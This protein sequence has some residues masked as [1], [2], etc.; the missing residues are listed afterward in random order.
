MSILEFIHLITRNKKWTIF[1]PL[2]VGL[3]VTL[4]I[5]STPH[6]YTSHMVIYTGFASGLNSDNEFDAKIDF[7]ATSSGFDNLINIV[8]SKDLCKEV[9]VKLLAYMLHNPERMDALLKNSNNNLL[10]QTLTVGFVGHYRQANQEATESNLFQHL[11]NDSKNS[12]L[13]QLIYGEKKNCF[14]IQ[15]LQTMTAERLGFSDML[16]ISYECEDPFTCQKTLELT[17]I[18]LLE[19]YKAIRIGEA[20]SAV[21]YFRQQ[22]KESKTRL[23]IAE[24]NLKKFKSD[25]KIINYY[26]QS[27]YFA[28]QNERIGLSISDLHQELDGYT[29]ALQQTEEK[30][31]K[32]WMVQL[33]SEKVVKL[34]DSLTAQ[35]TKNAM[36]QVKNGT[37]IS[38]SDSGVNALKGSL[39]GSVDK[40]YALNNTIEGVPGKKLVEQWL[41]LV[42]GKEETES[43]L[44][45]LMGDKARFDKVFVSLS[46]IG[47][48]LTKY[49]KEVET[50]EKEYLNLLHNLN[51]AI[52]RERNLEV[53]QTI[54]VIDDADM[55]TI[56][57]PSKQII[58]I[59][60]SILAAFILA[61]VIL[62]IRRYL[63]D[64][65][66]S[67]IRMERL[68][69]IKTATAFISRSLRNIRPKAMNKLD[70]R[71]F[72]RWQIAMTKLIETN[73]AS[74]MIVLSINCPEEQIHFYLDKMIEY[75]KTK[76]IEA[77]YT[78]AKDYVVRLN[79]IDDYG[80][81]IPYE[82]AKDYAEGH[83]AICF[84]MA[85]RPYPELHPKL[86]LDQSKI[87]FIFFDASQKLNEYQIQ[88]VEDWKKT[89]ITVKGILVN[90]AEQYIAEYLG[91]IPRKRSKLRK[92]VKK[93]IKRY[94]S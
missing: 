25:N 64:S 49:E 22:V 9:S 84:V 75:L 16:K 24:D 80:A 15:T 37:E 73:E 7:H 87:I 50:A 2:L 8:G 72:E 93:E 54:D 56:P 46:P 51:Q 20:S 69:G 48:E 55:P 83:N 57:N 33:Q 59:I 58:I 42:V 13:S 62:I 68:L 60:A 91:E 86:V 45:A 23:E 82:P 47:S 92:F 90:T 17:K 74:A 70:K 35:I 53:S 44:K 28:D 34:R 5:W 81:L 32:R 76:S 88:L 71:S 94:A 36:N 38:Y 41:T 65:L 85:E 39:A 29:N 61:V 77:A 66:A 10:N 19:K 12:D 63:D 6:I 11:D 14:N 40:L 1:F 79:A 52:L 31:G 78:P 4:F 30:I 89:D 67:P 3:V 27:K 26:E 43:K 21:A 18:V